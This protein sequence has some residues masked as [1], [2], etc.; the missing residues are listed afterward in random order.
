MSWIIE[1]KHSIEELKTLSPD[2]RETLTWEEA[3]EFVVDDTLELAE[4]QSLKDTCATPIEALL[5]L[6]RIKSML[7]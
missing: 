2:Q 6:R 4:W 7:A 3:D 5:N 1:P